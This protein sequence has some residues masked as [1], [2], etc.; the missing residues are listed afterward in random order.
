MKTLVK[1]V[2]K[3]IIPKHWW[4]KA[5]TAIEKKRHDEFLTELTRRISKFLEDKPNK[6][7]EELEVMAYLQHN[8][9]S[10]FPYDFEKEYDKSSILVFRDESNGLPYVVHEQKKLFFKRS[11]T[12]AKVR[13]LYHGLQLDQDHRSP[14]LYLNRDFDL[15][16]EDVIADIGAAEGNFSL[17][18]IEKVKKIYLFECDHEWIEALEA[19]FKPWKEKVTICN[20]F[21][22]NSDSEDAISLDTF[23]KDHDDITFL[24]VDIEGEEARFLAGAKHFLESKS[25]FKLA[26]CTY[27]KKH[28]AIEFTEILEGYGLKVQPSERFMIFYHDPTIGPP[29]LRRGLLRAEKNEKVNA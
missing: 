18:N 14:H 20:K 12:V 8:P 15:N 10:V 5:V 7:S 26:I 24:K 16:S 28:D 13:S 29:Y 17:S 25:K 4:L 23:V 21:V 9:I 6:T 19:T 27:H 2:L 22:S 11:Y 1:T 3:K